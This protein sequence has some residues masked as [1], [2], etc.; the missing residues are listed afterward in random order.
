[1]RI[2]ATAALLPDGWARDVGIT[3][4][5]ATIEQV[6]TGVAPQP[7]DHRAEILLPGMA[8][9]HSHSFQ[10]GFAGLTER[11]GPGQDS[12]WTWRE[13]MY[14]FALS[15]SPD[16]VQAVAALACIEMLEAGYTRLGEFHYLH[17]GPD[18][19]PYDNPAEMSQRIFAAAADTG[20]ALTHLPVLYAHGGFG[21]E[22]AGEGQRRFL[23]GLDDYLQLIETCDGYIR[24]QDRVGIAPHSL[25]AATMAEIIALAE[26]FPGR[27]FHIH[28]SEQVKEVE[29]CLAHTGA[30]PVEYLLANAPV[31]PSWCLIHATHLIKN[32][33]RR[34]ATSGA[35]VGL[36]PIT[37]ANLGD[38]IFPA[39]EFL[40]QRGR[41][42]IGTD[43]NVE[44]TLPG[45][46]KQL[47]YSQR[48]SLR[49]R[50]ALAVNGSTG[51]SLFHAALSGGAQSLDAPN[52]AIASGHPADLVAL[53][54]NC[55]LE[56]PDDRLMDRWVFGR[57]LR[58]ADLWAAGVHLVR[59]GRHIHRTRIATDYAKAIRDVLNR[60]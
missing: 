55:R 1:M 4:T 45:E 28:I 17:H 5:D 25:R 7:G 41:I 33:I 21:P 18:G 44:I 24:P 39:V 13:M 58:V 60:I 19:Q 36:C 42:G 6:Q 46:L 34:I 32:E 50:N 9:L 56:M 53:S 48:L 43:S 57:D 52:P 40:A 3:L 47:E 38:G 16:E 35:V 59:E 31:G 23:H 54:D 8:N 15:L 29:D 20:I 11:R 22:P 51:A 10:R 26:A 14:R 49:L 30:R 27:P 37:E 2:H 12:F